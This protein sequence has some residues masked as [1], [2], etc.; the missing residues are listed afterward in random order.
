M[1]IDSKSWAMLIA[2]SVLWGGSFLFA[3]IALA[4]IPPVSLVALRVTLAAAALLIWLRARGLSIPREIW[5]ACAVMGFLNNLIPF[6]LIFWG[7]QT[8]GVGLAA[9]VNATTPLWTIVLAHFMTADERLTGTRLAGVIVGVAGVAVLVGPDA[10]GGLGESGW[11]QLALLG[12][13]LSYACALIWARRFRGRNPIL[14]AAGQLVASSSMAIPLALFVD[15]PW[16]LAMPSAE[17][18]GAVLALSVAC[19]ALAYNLYFAIMARAGAGNAA[20]VTML[21]PPS[22]MAMGWIVLGETPGV[23]SLAGFAIILAGLVLVD[24]RLVHRR[25]VG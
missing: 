20:L 2:L 12:A 3:K 21:I 18:W 24:G 5:A 16:T 9:I 1:K 10:L 19:T 15:A 23:L 11:A 6:G 4:E 22:A 17:I 25:Q 14:P 7:Q 13:T 8:I